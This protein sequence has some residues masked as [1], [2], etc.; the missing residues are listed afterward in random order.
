[1][2]SE[3]EPVCSYKGTPSPTSESESLGLPVPQGDG[4]RQGQAYHS[5]QPTPTSHSLSQD[6]T[7]GDTGTQEI[8]EKVGQMPKR[9]RWKEIKE[10]KQSWKELSDF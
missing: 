10:K 6:T 7:P 8:M 4:P 1:M 2:Y 5:H 3:Q 9:T